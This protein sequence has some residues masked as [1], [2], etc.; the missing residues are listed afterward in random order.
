MSVLHKHAPWP[1]TQENGHRH[2]YEHGHMNTDID[3]D[4][5]MDMAI[6]MDTDMDRDT[7]D[8]G[9]KTINRYRAFTGEQILKHL[10]KF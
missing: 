7:V 2:G 9:L 6:N 8:L 1:R 3:T 10:G 4:M 5:D